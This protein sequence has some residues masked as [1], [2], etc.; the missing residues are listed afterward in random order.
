MFS[1]SKINK[2]IVTYSNINGNINGTLNTID[3]HN[4]NYNGINKSKYEKGNINY[5]NSNINKETQY[6][7]FIAKKNWG[8]IVPKIGKITNNNIN[9]I[10]NNKKKVANCLPNT[11]EEEY[12]YKMGYVYQNKIQ[13]EDDFNKNLNNV[14]EDYNNFFLTRGGNNNF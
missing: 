2:K 5:N 12:L 3:N 6:N 10:L 13:K 11:N 4:K 7:G 8:D 9:Q 1:D 14:D